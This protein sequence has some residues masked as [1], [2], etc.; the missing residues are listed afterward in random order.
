MFM[1]TH[2][3]K[4]DLEIFEK[5]FRSAC[6]PAR[7]GQFYL[8]SLWKIPEWLHGKTV[9]APRLET[10]VLC[11]YPVFLYSEKEFIFK[12]TVS[13]KTLLTMCIFF[14]FSKTKITT[15]I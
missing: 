12:K 3:L 8:P 10:C 14:F 4:E 15:K 1:F 7:F 2:L 13:K 11:S 9:I 6:L 5:F